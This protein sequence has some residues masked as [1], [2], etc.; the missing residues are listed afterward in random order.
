MRAARVLSLVTLLAAGLAGAALANGRITAP[1]TYDASVGVIPAFDIQ[2]PADIKA[3][4]PPDFQNVG[5]DLYTG[6]VTISLSGGI[7]TVQFQGAREDGAK[8]NA[9][10]TFSS[11]WTGLLLGSLTVG[12]SLELGVITSIDYAHMLSAHINGVGTVDGVNQRVIAR[13]GQAAEFL[14]LRVLKAPGP[15][16]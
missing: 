9:T 15:L 7:Y 10:A 3:K 2:V 6:Q 12:S 16:R 8:L 14:S 5:P 1:G 4:Y 13:L 11:D